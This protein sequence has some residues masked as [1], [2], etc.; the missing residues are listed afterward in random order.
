MSS[1]TGGSIKI[2]LVEDN[3]GDVRLMME[4][5]KEAQLNCNTV[6]AKDGVEAMDILN[7]EGK[8]GNIDLVILDLNLPK[9]D[10]REVLS[11]IKSDPKLK[12]IPVVVLTSSSSKEDITQSYE[13]HANCYIT[14]PLD[15]KE[16]VN[17]VKRIETFW[18]SMVRLPKSAIRVLLIEDNE[19]DARLV[20]EMLIDAGKGDFELINTKDLKS[21]LDVLGSQNV[22]ILILDLNLPDSAGIKS[23]H[24]A[25][26]KFPMLPIIV[27]TGLNDEELGVKTVQDGAQSYILKN[28]VNA[29]LLVRSI[30]FAIERNKLR[31]ANEELVNIIVHE[32][33][34]PM[35]VI[36]EG[37][38]QIL[39]GIHGKVPLKQKEYVKMVYDNAERLGRLVEELLDVA[40]I[41]LGKMKLSFSTVDIVGLINN[42]FTSFKPIADKKHIEFK[43]TL[44]DRAVKIEL[45]KDRIVQVLTNLLSNAFKFTEKGVVELTMVERDNDVECFV[46]DTGSGIDKKDI[47]L[48]FNKYQRVGRSDRVKGTGLGLFVSKSI[49]ELHGGRMSVESK[50]NEGSTFSFALPK[51]H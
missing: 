42:V 33:K 38:S 22:D 5:M 30:K 3:P 37:A 13:A 7:Q 26:Q 8:Y 23:F 50:L 40:R 45:D 46:K 20:K 34:S 28:E 29:Q 48:M 31:I 25:H 36:K 2:L 18:V 27:M 6:I 15:L 49:V 47:P 21:G 1:Q 41:D 35:T 32:L 24:V 12:H 16:F 11:E 10:G 19:G 14:K 17:V 39:D 43:K 9:K 44:P 4:A 51:E